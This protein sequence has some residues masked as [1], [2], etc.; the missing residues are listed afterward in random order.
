VGNLGTIYCARY[1]SKLHL[2]ETED[3]TRTQVSLFWINLPLQILFLLAVH[4]LGL[5]HTSVTPL[6]TFSYLAVS[7]LLLFVILKFGRALSSLLWNHG[8]DPDDH[9]LPYLT[10]ICDVLGTVAIVATFTFL[11]YVGDRDQDVG[12]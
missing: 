7:N 3:H 10:S 8:L 12:E 5:G 2:D 4:F 9:A 1:S 11:F 6:F